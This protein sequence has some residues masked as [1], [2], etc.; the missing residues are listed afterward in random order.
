MPHIHVGLCCGVFHSSS[1]LLANLHLVNVKSLAGVI[2]SL[3]FQI[4][5]LRMSVQ[6]DGARSINLA[7]GFVCKYSN[8]FQPNSTILTATV[9]A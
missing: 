8:Y 3:Y 1:I 7:S 2:L 5:H 9:M 6:M 4:A